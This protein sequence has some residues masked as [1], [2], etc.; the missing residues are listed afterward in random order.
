MYH[1]KQGVGAVFAPFW[2]DAMKAWV[3]EY[4]E[5]DAKMPG[6]V[7]ESK[8]Y[9]SEKQ[10]AESVY[11]SCRDITDRSAWAHK[12]HLTAK[13]IAF[14]HG[15]HFLWRVMSGQKAEKVR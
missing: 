6:G 14:G 12:T 8:V 11:V 3:V 5:P 2:S 4:R 1:D 10:A 15:D 7:W 13:G 9:C